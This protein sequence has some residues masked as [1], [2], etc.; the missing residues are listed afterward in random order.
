MKGQT[1][2]AQL[3]SAGQ[4]AAFVLLL[5]CGHCGYK[6]PVETKAGDFERQCYACGAINKSHRGTINVF[7]GSKMVQL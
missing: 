6:S 7:L 5:E 1:A 3:K 2:V 4:Y